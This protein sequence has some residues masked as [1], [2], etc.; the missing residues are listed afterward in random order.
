MGRVVSN[1]FVCSAILGVAV[2]GAVVLYLNR[3]EPA[4]VEV[5]STPL[6]VDVAEVVK[7]DVPISIDSQGT[8]SAR[9]Q[10]L[11]IAEVSGRVVEV[12]D[13][14]KAGGF[15]EAGDMLLQ[16]DDRD[17]RAE[18]K[19]A[20]AAVASAKSNLALEKGRAETGGL[21]AGLGELPLF[22][23]AAVA[24]EEQCDTLRDSLRALDVDALSPREALEMLYSLKAEAGEDGA[25][26]SE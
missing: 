6:V 7:Q 2:A 3:P 16:I 8:V 19:R 18:L 12:S 10:T 1:L 24:A 14:F 22:A 9:T 23:A 26:S 5:E 4:K 15:F 17:Y 25:R 21:A 11:L 20:E 13:R